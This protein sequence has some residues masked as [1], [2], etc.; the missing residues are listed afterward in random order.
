M[1]VKINTELAR[2]L[3]AQAMLVIRSNA[4][5]N[6]KGEWVPDEKKMKKT[7]YSATLVAAFASLFNQI[8]DEF[9]T[10][11]NKKNGKKSMERPKRK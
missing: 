1:D 7:G 3:R 10:I 5:Q 6:S 2:V 4:K 8:Q 11:K 9:I